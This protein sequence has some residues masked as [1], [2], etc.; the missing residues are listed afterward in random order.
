MDPEGL[1]A[2]KGPT[3]RGSHSAPCAHGCEHCEHSAAAPPAAL[4]PG[5]RE[6]WGSEHQ[7]A[8]VLQGVRV[9]WAMSVPTQ[10]EGL[11][12]CPGENKH[13]CSH[14]AASLLLREMKAMDFNTFQELLSR[15]LGSTAE[16]KVN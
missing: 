8:V 3:C 14:C 11:A 10:K 2:P 12:A 4:R 7:C 1:L 13:E 9:C 5:A 16:E 6:Q 15:S